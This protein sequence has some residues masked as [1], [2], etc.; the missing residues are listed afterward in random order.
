MLASHHFLL[1]LDHYLKLDLETFDRFLPNFIAFWELIIRLVMLLSS[2]LQWWIC[3]KIAANFDDFTDKCC[4]YCGWSDLANS[5]SYRSSRHYLAQWSPKRCRSGWARPCLATPHS[6]SK[7]RKLRWLASYC[8]SDR[9]RPG[10]RCNSSRR[11]ASKLE[12]WPHG[13]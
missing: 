10:K 8:P 13:L 1:Y 5:N 12:R 4:C 11:W 6:R 7:R 3:Q 9:S 2:D